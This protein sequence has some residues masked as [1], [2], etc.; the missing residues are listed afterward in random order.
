MHRV[1]PVQ[2]SRPD[3]GDDNGERVRKT[4]PIRSSRSGARQRAASSSATSGAPKKTARPKLTAAT[5]AAAPAAKRK[6]AAK[7]RATAGV[8]LAAGTERESA[9]P[10]A[11]AAIEAVEIRPSGTVVSRRPAVRRPPILHVPHH[12]VVPLKPP[13]WMLEECHVA[14]AR[15]GDQSEVL[16]L[17][18]GLPSPPSRAEFH[19]AVD[20]PDHDSANRLVARL[21]GR[22]VGHVEILPRDLLVG[23]AAVRGAV[24][25]RVAVLPECRGAGHGQRLRIACGSWGRWSPSRARG[26]RRP[27]TSLAG[28]CSAATPR[29]P[30]D[31]PTSSRDCSRVRSGTARR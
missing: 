31:R 17:L 24:I 11:A 22:I 14:P 1:D 19:A 15:A 16:Q 8:K 5:P 7:P 18:S 25:D 9:A 26:S 3:F 20:H 12:P 10:I 23:S 28:A 30:G 21:A 4:R 2:R 29:R 27:S 13:A 6:A